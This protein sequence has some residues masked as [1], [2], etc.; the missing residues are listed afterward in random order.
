MRTQFLFASLLM[1]SSNA[2]IAQICKTS[3]STESKDFVTAQKYIDEKIKV[4]ANSKDVATLGDAMLSQLIT[5]KSPVISSWLKT[6]NLDSKSEDEIVRAWRDYFARN[7]ILSSYPQKE[8]ALNK[9]IE[10]LMEDVNSKVISVKF[11]SKIQ[12]IFSEAQTLAIKKIKSLPLAD[13][14]K[15][16]ITQR[17]GAIALH[18]MG[19]FADSHFNSVPLEFL[20]WGIA[21]DPKFNSINMGVNSLA[22]TSDETLLATFSHEIGHSIDSCRWSSEFD[23]AWPFQKVGDCLRSSK[24]IGAKKR[25]DGKFESEIKSGRINASMATFLKANPTCNKSTYPPI[26]T[27]ADQLPESFADWFAAEVV[28]Q[29]EKISQDIRGDLCQDKQLNP[30]S[31]YVSNSDRLNGIYFVNP[32]LRQKIGLTDKATKDYCAYP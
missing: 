32:L 19:K 31:S 7:F 29:K 9:A 2:A 4:F 14:I 16:K 15:N 13:D 5:A 26:G 17:I 21:Y 6:R 1:I 28:S 20:A 8:A 23:G 12:S 3:Q 27:Q 25:D 18:W 22:Y 11:K 10:K 30:G 24:S